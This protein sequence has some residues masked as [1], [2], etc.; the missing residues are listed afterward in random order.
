MN[1]QP[2]R[3]NDSGAESFLIFFSEILLSFRLGDSIIGRL[4][5]SLADEHVNNQGCPNYSA[6]KG[7]Q[8]AAEDRPAVIISG[9]LNATSVNAYLQWSN[10]VCLK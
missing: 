7:T 1:D 3:R 2:D 8:H 9:P 5:K 4:T 10:P 6:G